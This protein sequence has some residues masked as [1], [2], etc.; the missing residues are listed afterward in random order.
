MNKKTIFLA[1]PM[2]GVHRPLAL[3]WRENAEKLL[4][5][6]FIILHAMRGRE[7]AE[8]F[9][10]YRAAI[11]RDKLDIISADIILVNDSFEGVSMIG[12]AMETIFAFERNKII[13]VFGQA[14]KD[15]YWLN[16]HLHT[17]CND[18]N[19][20]CIYLNELFK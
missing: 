18:L 13:I 11:A 12:T 3:A 6:N 8:T 16:Y 4:A 10:D 1:G 2:K 19:T 5:S 14:H 9:T 17:R 7:E 15:D 20:A